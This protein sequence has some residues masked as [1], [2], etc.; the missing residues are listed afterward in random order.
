M[1]GI[2]FVLVLSTRLAAI[3]GKRGRRE[4]VWFVLMLVSAAVLSVLTGIIIMLIA[5]QEE[6]LD[7]A[8]GMSALVLTGFL[9]LVLERVL[10]SI[11]PGR[12]L[13]KPAPPQPTGPQVAFECTHCK[14]SATVFASQRGS[15]VTCVPCGK[16]TMV[17]P[18]A[19]AVP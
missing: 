15:V 19:T 9:F 7:M 14:A 17:P 11:A 3:A 16:P 12:Y 13:K 10:T 5:P 8:I 2:I 6:N 1:L 18:Q 4:W